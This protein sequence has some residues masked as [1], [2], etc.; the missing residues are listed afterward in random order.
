MLADRDISAPYYWRIGVQEGL[1]YKY[2][3]ARSFAI[4]WDGIDG[5]DI[6]GP[7]DLVQ[8]TVPQDP[9]V[10]SWSAINIAGG[11][12]NGYEVQVSDADNF[13]APKTYF[14]KNI[15]FAVPV[16]DLAD[17]TTYF[18]RV[19][20]VVRNT[21]SVVTARSAWSAVRRFQKRWPSQPEQYNPPNSFSPTTDEPI[22]GWSPIDGAKD[23]QIQVSPN[24]DW[25]N[26]V[27]YGGSDTD[28][29]SQIWGKNTNYGPIQALE[30]NQYYW[31]VRARDAANHGG[32]WSP[33]EHFQK[34]WLDAPA[35]IGPNNEE[36]VPFP[37]LQW[38][39]VPNAAKYR[40]QIAAD[41]G[42]VRPPLCDSPWIEVETTNTSYSPILLGPN[43]E[44]GCGAHGAFW[45]NQRLYWRVRALDVRT[46][47]AST[48][49][50]SPW[51]ENGV[52]RSFFIDIDV[53]DYLALTSGETT[54]APVLSWTPVTFAAQYE[55]KLKQGGSSIPYTTDS[56]TFTPPTLPT[57]AYSWTVNAKLQSGWTG[58]YQSGGN[59]VYAPAVDPSPL[60]IV[61]PPDLT[62]SPLIPTLTWR[63]TGPFTIWY[64]TDGSVYQNLLLSEGIGTTT[65]FTTY[66]PTKFKSSGTY[67]WY[68][69]TSG[70]TTTP[71]R[72]TITD[73]PLAAQIGPSNNLTQTLTPRLS[74][75]PVS[76]AAGYYVIVAKDVN[77][78]AIY[79]D[80]RTDPNYRTIWP[81][82]SPRDAYPD[83][84]AGEGY[85]WMI[86]PFKSGYKVKQVGVVE[87]AGARTFN[88]KSSAPVLQLPAQDVTTASTPTFSWNRIGGAKY[89]HIAVSTDPLFATNN[90]DDINTDTT[91]Y[92]S[93]SKVYP[94]GTHYWRVQGIDGSGNGLTWSEA[95]RY[96]KVS[97]SPSQIQPSVGITVA[98]TP[99]FAWTA[100]PGAIKYD[101][102]VSK[103]ANFGALYD[104]ALI[105]GGS[106]FVP[107]TKVYGPGTYYWRI[108][109]RDAS[110]NPMSWSN[111]GQGISFNVD[112]AGPSPIS[113]NGAQNAVVGWVFRWESLSGAASYRIEIIGPDGSIF[114][115]K[116]SLAVPYWAPTKTMSNG[117]YHW[118]VYA[119]DSSGNE[120]P[121]GPD[122]SFVVGTPS[123]PNTVRKI[124]VPAANRK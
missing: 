52:P 1:T 18:W 30:D 73:L 20:G 43:A 85:F 95:R 62:Q 12:N 121:A 118:R 28:V 53:P 76:Y 48:S 24:G 56:T 63:G 22:F 14:T 109:G 84:Q 116:D 19:A 45:T 27:V 123:D 37:L 7:E 35:I 36:S 10:L 16:T 11:T 31:R 65:V 75:Q 4:R 88:K 3:G 91:T 68:V 94:D 42:F 102:Q 51:S 41:P 15:L 13:A 57:G 8:I 108:R 110:D 122:A 103:Q 119:K 72:F 66:T 117:T 81:T 74:W 100:V 105:V 34:A 33:V 58:A 67:W 39:A 106:S 49:L 79:H 77:F 29:A 46:T 78:N 64:S 93:V 6:T 55:V 25:S 80:G 17:D 26:N 114:E 111:G 69:Q 86:V 120:G 44:E 101:L 32:A 47:V 89:Y 82:F 50:D 104:T 87:Y 2:T 115:T 92:S 112:L 83:T 124:F 40:V 54:S 113:P 59:F 71:R 38:T 90:I 96:V 61:S 60:A 97:S 99:Y 23:Y 5:P 9:L 98:T 21:V 70:E 107:M